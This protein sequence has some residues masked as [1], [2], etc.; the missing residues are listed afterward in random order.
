[1]DM[2]KNGIYAMEDLLYNNQ[3]DINKFNATMKTKIGVESFF[4]TSK[5]HEM[6]HFR[7]EVVH[8]SPNLA[9]LKVLDTIV[10]G[11]ERITNWQDIFRVERGNTPTAAI[12]KIKADDFKVYTGSQAAHARLPGGRFGYVGFDVT[13]DK[14]LYKM[15][16]GVK[17]TWIADAQWSLIETMLEEA[18]AAFSYYILDLLVDYG[19]ANKKA[20][21]AFSTDMYQTLVDAIEAIRARGFES[22]QIV[23]VCDPT[24]E[25]KLLKLDVVYNREKL[26]EITKAREGRVLALFR[27]VPVFSTYAQ[28]STDAFVQ[29]KN[30]GVIVYL[31]QDLQLE[32]FDDPLKGLEGAVATIRLDY[33]YAYTEALQLASTA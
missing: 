19:T 24:C 2:P 23:I 21:S 30:S 11:S 17:K 1:M 9:A 33:K 10:K 13:G 28:V 5:L 26:E 15:P 32:E 4:A 8:V 25:G 6:M 3:E 12:P 18:G 20:D 31:R 22:S 14:G 27:D 29:A 16:L 7:E